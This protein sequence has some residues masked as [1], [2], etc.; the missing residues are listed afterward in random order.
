M[1]REMSTVEALSAAYPAFTD[2]TD[3]DPKHPWYVPLLGSESRPDPIHRLAVRLN[4]MTSESVH[5][6]TGFRGNGKSTQLRRL[7]QELESAGHTVFLIDML[8]WMMV[9]KPVELSD[10]LLSVVGA[11]DEA[12]RREGFLEDGF[13]ARAKSWLEA[14]A[15]FENL[16]LELN[17]GPVKLKTS[18]KSDADFKERLQKHLRGHVGRLVQGAREHVDAVVEEVRRTRKDPHAKVVLLVDSVEQLRGAGQDAHAVQESA[19]ELFVTQAKNLQF[20]K[21]HVVY[22]FPPSLL[23]LADEDATWLR[24]IHERKDVAL[25]SVEHNP[26]LVRF[27]DNNLIMNYENGEPW[28]DVHPLLLPEIERLQKFEKPG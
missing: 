14:P 10:F 7:Q 19:R 24:K 16:D 13:W 21:L 17:T 11:L 4:L 23:P 26:T 12:K 22:T 8:D 27:F 2:E 1:A 5:M 6:L 28:Y 18:L 9:S 25:D 3:V 15:R 20:P